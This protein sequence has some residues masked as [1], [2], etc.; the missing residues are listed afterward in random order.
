MYGIWTYIAIDL[1]LLDGM[2]SSRTVNNNKK[3]SISGK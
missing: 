2:I 1:N 3:K